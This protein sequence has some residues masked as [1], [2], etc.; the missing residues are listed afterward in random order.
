V[1]ILPPA[2]WAEVDDRINRLAEYDW[3]VFTSANGVQSFLGRLRETGRDMRALANVKLA[4]IGPGT[5]EALREFQLNADLV[6]SE[7]RSESLAAA[8]AQLA[9]GQRILLARADRGRDVL[10]VELAKVAHVDQV[11]VYRQ[12]DAVPPDGV[13]HDAL[14][15]GEIDF[16]TLTS[17]NVARSV[18]GTLDEVGRARAHA[19]ELR[20]VTISPVTTAAVSELGYPVAAEARDY[21]TDGLLD[22]LVELANKS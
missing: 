19:G 16:V 7:Y 21:T 11:T 3:L 20:L 5:A 1:E 8:L 2:D 15:R 18:L 22:A 9:A 17:A 13:V 6:P 4:A 10:R 12:T 14:R